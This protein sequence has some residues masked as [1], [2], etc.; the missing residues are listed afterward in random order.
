M[1]KQTVP[2][3]FLCVLGKI[4]ADDFEYEEKFP[5]EARLQSEVNKRRCN[6]KEI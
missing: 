5:L 2:E 6:G 3:V 4:I 1:S